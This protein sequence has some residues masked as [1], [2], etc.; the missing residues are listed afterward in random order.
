MRAVTLA[1][2]VIALWAHRAAACPCC[3][4][5]SKYE[6]MMPGHD[7]TQE[8]LAAQYVASGVTLGA[9]PKEKDVWRVLTTARF[10]VQQR[11]AATLRIVDGAHVPGAVTH[12]G[13]ERIE[14]VHGLAL[15]HGHFQITLEGAVY[16]IA[17]CGRDMVCLV[18]S[19]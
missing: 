10:T 19:P 11:G 3:D 16:T 7:P 17:P 8:V 14:I 18:R 15:H 6:R 9:H 1:L 13:G 2:L 12:A 5:C 4:P